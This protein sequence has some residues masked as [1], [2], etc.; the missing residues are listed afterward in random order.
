MTLNS[1]EAPSQAPVRHAASVVLLRDGTQGLEVFLMRR[2]EQS[3]VMGGA[4]VFPGGKLDA[5]DEALAAS[6]LLDQASLALHQTL[7]ETSTPES[8]AAGLFVA[9]LR[10]TYE[11]AGILF[12]T[13]SERPEQA[14]ALAQL[15]G[16]PFAT[17]L[18]TQRLTLHTRAVHPWSRWIT[19]AL[20]PLMSKRFDTRF[21]VA[22]VPHTQTARHDNF[23]T[24]QSVWLAPRTALEQYWDGQ[25]ALAPPQIMGLAHLARHAHVASVLQEAQQRRPPTILPQVFEE[26]G[27]RFMCY[28]GDARHDLPHK[29]IPG[30]TRLCIRKGRFE[31]SSGFEGFFSD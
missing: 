11:E 14:E 30:P 13:S 20:S 8:V 29:A 17:M 31:P 12:S 26:D 16:T 7:G 25:I 23:E 18:Q 5:Q 24:T 19:P 21:F 2:S 27:L 9:A 6:G 28:P 15:R 4:Y 3:D 1:S 10:E 22:A